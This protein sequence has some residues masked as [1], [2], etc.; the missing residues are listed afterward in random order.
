MARV[1]G[2]VCAV[3]V[4]A[5][6]ASSAPGER[7]SPPLAKLVGQS[8]VTG[9]DGTLPDASLLRRIRRGEVG[10]VIFFGGNVASP[11]A[12]RAPVAKLQATVARGETHPC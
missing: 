11:G 8:I 12:V 7:A 5:L 9:M 1:A 10:G 2:L 3:L 4:A 6:L